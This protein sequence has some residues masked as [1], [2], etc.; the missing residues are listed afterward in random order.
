M[1]TKKTPEAAGF[2]V[3]LSASGAFTGNSRIGGCLHGFH[4]SAGEKSSK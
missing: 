4:A 1:S 3:A 2:H